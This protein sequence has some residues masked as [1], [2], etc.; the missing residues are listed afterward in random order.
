MRDAFLAINTHAGYLVK[1]L[2]KL[3]HKAFYIDNYNKNSLEKISK[4]HFLNKFIETI[5]NKHSL[6]KLIY[7]SGLEDK[8]SIFKLLESKTTI[9]GNNLN[10]LEYCNNILN[11][12]K[13][14]KKSGLKIPKTNRTPLNNNIKSIT[15]HFSSSGGLGIKFFKSIKKGHY[16]QEFIPGPTFSVSFFITRKKFFLLGY[17]KLFHLKGFHKNPFIHAGAMNIP[18]IEKSE[19]IEKSVKN[20]SSIMGLRGYNSID[21]KIFNNEIFVLDVNPRITSTFKIY[22]ELYSNDLLRLQIG[23]ENK[24]GIFMKKSLRKFYG[25]VYVFSNKKFKFFKD[26]E[27]D[28]IISD[29]PINGE[30]IEKDSPVFTINCSAS[31]PS[32]VVKLL[33]KEINTAKK[34][35]NCYDIDI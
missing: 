13:E 2:K 23:L 10:T 11:L 26:M 14:L 18:K 34:N 27:N 19:E 35:Y 15:K 24:K 17:N 6:I 7:G 29:L 1:N 31:S 32:S 28:K 8:K 9:Q 4:R 12:E 20:F 16:Y 21:F 22:N 25:F 3:G 33:R 30:I 5:Q